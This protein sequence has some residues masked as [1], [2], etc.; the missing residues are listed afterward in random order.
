MNMHVKAEPAASCMDLIQKLTKASEFSTS[1][2]RALAMGHPPS[3]ARAVETVLWA[4]GELREYLEAVGMRVD[5]VVT[6]PSEEPMLRVSPAIREA[7]KEV[8]NGPA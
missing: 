7:I 2:V 5:L 6:A 4:I 3:S 1:S 8:A